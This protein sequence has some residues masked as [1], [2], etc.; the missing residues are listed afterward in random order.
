MFVPEH[1]GK[2]GHLEEDDH[3]V[4]RR[5]QPCQ[6]VEHLQGVGCQNRGRI[7]HSGYHGT[8]ETLLLSKVVLRFKYKPFFSDT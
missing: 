8:D 4:R 2:H 1:P 5:V 6:A 7:L 3:Q